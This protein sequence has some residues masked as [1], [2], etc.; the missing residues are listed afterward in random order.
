LHIATIASTLYVTLQRRVEDAAERRGHLS[1]TGDFAVEHVEHTRDEQAGERRDRPPTDG[2]VDRRAGVPRRAMPSPDQQAHTADDRD[3]KT[4][5]RQT[6]RR[7]AEAN[8][9]R[10]DLRPPAH[11]GL[12]DR[13][14]AAAGG[15]AGAKCLK[16][17]VLTHG[18]TVRVRFGG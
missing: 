15:A 12:A 8:A 3:D 4:E 6:V 1:G 13:V 17:A 5:K 11:D 16:V 2:R 7:C 10:P 14:R 18:E 9:D